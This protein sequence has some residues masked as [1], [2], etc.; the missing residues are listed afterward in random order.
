MTRATKSEDRAL[1][2]EERLAEAKITEEANVA[3]LNKIVKYEE[4]KKANQKLLAARRRAIGPLIRF[5]SSSRSRTSILP[6]FAEAEKETKTTDPYQDD[7]EP[8]SLAHPMDQLAIETNQKQETRQEQSAIPKADQL[9]LPVQPA[10]P[11]YSQ[12]IT[13]ENLIDD[14]PFNLGNARG[15]LLGNDAH[16]TKKYPAKPLCMLSGL[17]ARYRD[18]ETGINY[19]NQ[20]AYTM[21][22]DAKTGSVPWN[23]QLR[24]YV[25]RP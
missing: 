8:P 17:P 3:S 4:E 7:K 16:L 11:C 13:F 19:G 2:Q 12:F 9:D 24:L 21:L 18:P 25:P 1:T 14:S 15:I 20:R 5:V 23:N 6:K 10:E 22:Q